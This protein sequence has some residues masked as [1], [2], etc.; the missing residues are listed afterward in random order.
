MATM[1]SLGEILLYNGSTARAHL[2]CI[3]RIN[4]NYIAT[5]TCSLVR[6]VISESI[7]TGIQDALGHVWLHLY[8]VPDI[9]IFKTND[10]IF[11]YDIT[12]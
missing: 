11:I 6:N 10:A 8:N 1:N 12:A 3:G 7:P 5:S 2:R 4:P 9:D